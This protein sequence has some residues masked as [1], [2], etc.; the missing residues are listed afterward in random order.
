MASDLDNP[1]AGTDVSDIVAEGKPSLKDIYNSVAGNNPQQ[2]A[3]VIRLSNQTGQPSSFVNQNLDESEK[4]A[5]KP[6]DTL[7]DDIEKQHPVAAR[8]LS[9]PR[10]MAVTHDD[11]PN[12]AAHEGVVKSGI[13]ALN[14]IRLQAEL[15]PLYEERAFTNARMIPGN[16]V[17]ADPVSSAFRSGPYVSAVMGIG[18]SDPAERLKQLDAR[19]K[20]LESQ[21]LG[22]IGWKTKALG[23]LVGLAP[24]VAG[25][26]GYGTAYGAAAGL[27]GPEAVP[28]GLG[29]GELAY[30]FQYGV[31]AVRERL[32]AENQ[33]R[34]TP[35]SDEEINTISV[36]GGALAAGGLRYGMK[37]AA[38]LLPAPVVEKLTALGGK[39]VLE[40]PLIFRRAVRSY[41]TGALKNTA[42]GA[43]GMTEFAAGQIAASD[44]AKASAG[45]K[46]DFGANAQ[47]LG[48]TAKDAALMFGVGAAVGAPFNPKW[49]E[50]KRVEAEQRFYKAMGDTAE[51]SK[52]RERLPE[53]HRR[54]IS[55]LTNNTPVSD[56][57]VPVEAWEAYWQGKTG[58][59]LGASRELG[60]EKQYAEAKATGES[61]KVPLDTW[62]HRLVGTPHFQGLAGDVKFDPEGL[63]PNQITERNA[64][65]AEK[66]AQTQQESE[67]AIKVDAAK[68]EAHDFIKADVIRQLTESGYL[69]GQKGKEKNFEAQ[70]K[71]VAAHYTTEAIRRGVDPKQ[72]YLN[73]APRIL[74]PSSAAKSYPGGPQSPS[75][76]GG[77][78]LG[79]SSEVLS[80]QGPFDPSI[81]GH[82]VFVKAHDEARPIVGDNPTRE[83][84][85]SAYTGAA[86]DVHDIKNIV[87]KKRLAE[88]VKDMGEAGV[89]AAEGKGFTPGEEATL[90]I[91][92]EDAMTRMLKT[93]RLAFIAHN[94]Q[95]ALD[96]FAKQD[97]GEQSDAKLVD[98]YDI[99]P[100]Q[101]GAVQRDAIKTP[102]FK[103]WFGKSKV[104]DAKGKPLVVYHG[105]ANQF[106]EFNSEKGNPE[107]DWGAGFYFTNGKEDVASNYAGFGPDLT[108]KITLR[109]EQIANENDWKYDDPRAQ[110]QAKEELA[111]HGGA[112]M[113]VYLKMEKPFR[114]GGKKETQLTM[115]YEYADPKDPESDIV[116]EK[117]T[118]V[119]FLNNL[120]EVASQYS[121]GGEDV[122]QLISRIAEE[123]GGDSISASRLR[124]LVDAGDQ[125]GIQYYEDENGKLAQHE[126]LRQALERSGFDGVIDE[127][128][129]KKFGSEKRIGKPM[130]GMDEKTIHYIAFKPESIKSAIGN[131]GT[132]D[133]NDPNIL[134]QQQ[135]NVPTFYSKLQRDIEARLPD[136][137]NKGQVEALL[138]DAKEDERKWSGIDEFLK[139]RQKIDK[140]EL[141]EHLRANQLEIKEIEKGENPTEA[142]NA[143]YRRRVEAYHQEMI[144]EAINSAEESGDAPQMTGVRE[145]ED[146]SFS[147]VLG[148][149]V[150]ETGIETNEAATDAANK[151]DEKIRSEWETTIGNNVNYRESED[152]VAEQMKNEGGGPRYSE[153][154]LPGGENY[155][156]LLLTMPRDRKARQDEYNRLVESGV[157]LMEA[158]DRSRE[159]HGDDFRSSH[160]DEPNILAHVRFNDRTDADGK[161]VLFIEEVQSDW[162]QKGRREGYKEPVK[163]WRVEDGKFGESEDQYFVEMPNGK[164]YS[165]GKG[166]V[167]NETE[168]KEYLQRYFG[169]ISKDKERDNISRVPDAPFKKTWHE[170]ALKRMIRYAAENGY[171][172]LAWTT[173]DQQSE[174]YDLSKQVSAIHYVE[175]LD[176]D[177]HVWASKQEPGNRG[178]RHVE[179]GVHPKERLAD[180][181]GKDIADK[182]IAGQGEVETNPT[183]PKEDT[184]TRTLSG[185]D[186]KVGGEGMKGFYDKILPSFANKFG[187]KWGAEVGESRFLQNPAQGGGTPMRGAEYM[188]AHSLPITDPLRN[189]ALKEGFPLFQGERGFFAAEQKVIGLLKNADPSTFMHES[190]HSWLESSF[191]FV[192]G[193]NATQDY[194][195]HWE[196]MRDWLKIAPDQ[197][198]LTREQQEKFAQ[199]FEDYLHEGRAP[200]EELQGIFSQFR[201]WLTEIYK[202]A[203][204]QEMSQPVRGFMDRMLA[205]DEELERATTE[206]GYQHGE[207]AAI[208]DAD[209]VVQNRVRT[210]QERARQAAEASLL[211]EQI[212]EMKDENRDFLT[213]ERE[214]LKPEVEAQVMNQPVYRAQEDLKSQLKR[215]S[216]PVDLSKRYLED[217]LEDHE[218]AAFEYAA[219]MNGF[220]GGQ[221]L[222]EAIQHADMEKDIKDQLD[223]AM[224][225]YADLRNTERI[226]DAALE[227][228]HT[229]KTGELLALEQQILGDLQHKKEIGEEATRRNRAEA[230]VMA[231]AAKRQA[232]ALLE[233]KPLRDAQAFKI[234]VT[235]ERNSAVRV[236]Q[237]LAKGDYEAAA[238]AKQ[239]QLLNHALAAEAFRNRT[240]IAKKMR[241]LDKFAERGQDL[242]GMPY[243]FAAQIDRLLAD[244]GIADPR[245]PE[246]QKTLLKI[247][248][249][250]D[251]AKANPQD[252]ANATGFIKDEDGQWR[253]ENLREFVARIN[254]NYHGLQLPGS[255]MNA[256]EGQLMQNQPHFT[257]GQLRD[258]HEAVKAISGVGKSFE[259]FLSDFLKGDI[260]DAAKIFRFK[261]EKNISKPYGDIPIFGTMEQGKVAA[262]V[263]SIKSV[264]DGM[265]ST[266]VNL[267]TLAEY[268]DRLEPDGPAKTYIYRPLERA[269]NEETKMR[270]EKA[271]EL[272]AIRK[273]YYSDKDL[274]KWGDTIDSWEQRTAN[275]PKTVKLTREN[276][277]VML[278]NRGSDSNLDRVMNGFGIDEQG[279]REIT[280]KLSKKDHEFAQEIWNYVDKFWP[281]ASALE[282]AVKGIE[283]EKVKARP[284]ETIHG[285]LK[286]GYYPLAYDF[287]KSPEAYKNSLERNALYKQ[288]TTT[289]A[290]TA[291]GFLKSRVTTLD[292]PVRLDFSG[293]YNHLDDVIHDITHR[294]AIIDVARFLNQPDAK[295][296]IM[297]AIGQDG[298]RKIQEDLKSVGSKQAEFLTP[299]EQTI[300]WFRFGTTFA[301]LGYRAI[302]FP[303]RLVEDVANSFREVPFKDLIGSV[304]DTLM[305]PRQSREFVR[306]KSVL[307]S[308]RAVNR[309]RDL[310]DMS[311]EWKGR[312]SLVKQ[313]AFLQDTIA[314]QAMSYPVWT[315]VY[316]NNLEKFG[317]ARARDM[318]D[319]AIVK[320]FG[321][322]REMDKV[323]AQRGGELNRIMSMY[324]SWH[325]MMFNRAWLQGKI[326]GLEYKEGNVG[327]ALAT[328]AKMTAMTWVVPAANEIFWAN[329][330]HNAPQGEDEDQKKKRAIAKAL[331]IPFAYFPMARN[332]AAY[333]VPELLGEK[334]RN[335]R[336]SPLEDSIE[337]IIKTVAQGGNIAGTKMGLLDGKDFDQRFAENAA[338]SASVLLG[339]PQTLNTWMFNFVDWLNNEGEANWRDILT[340]RSKR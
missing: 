180:V 102:E 150:I 43:A 302:I 274:A 250:M 292:R 196:P 183:G 26:A 265:I 47:E 169:G 49:A 113:P 152:A 139:G 60:V 4:A 263:D 68:R 310:I 178:D 93:R 31:G 315:A 329:L 198:K 105:T 115:E 293:L 182:I 175:R 212:A 36:L 258:V 23:G 301:T 131:Q 296:A 148:D 10:N 234:Y 107:S 12:V 215:G 165:V 249:D 244:N 190:A 316:K 309:E 41:L 129:N 97:A 232:Q 230:K 282:M 202:K 288:F 261:V 24:L 149:E 146:G 201:R 194:L 121:G 236:S 13:K 185:L 227:A 95:A 339:Y 77:G 184:G 284:V 226:R 273:R 276:A 308:N 108:Q 123:A 8:F 132:F 126:I 94:G 245:D 291:Q 66:I 287:D 135:P 40:D 330:F 98:P 50:S 96:H 188:D 219:E 298:Y 79:G 213:G 278:L 92:L 87:T 205:T 32:M 318:A 138:R 264:P 270:S 159:S 110:K 314:D 204:G 82:P 297:D 290:H 289:A 340:R 16:V 233:S 89:K 214:R 260:R 35:L 197:E 67:E 176:G 173:G 217:K 140:K 156:E 42:Q 210:L 119:D 228:I 30:N 74:G 186:L 259:R 44:V 51:A 25:G 122:E 100:L 241:F 161:K 192:K 9:D 56:V 73:E 283:P 64:T 247:A 285:T 221:Q 84:A 189:A 255:V 229:G 19:I 11:I 157:P 322:G 243:G 80:Q 199:A 147:V 251:T 90:K 18:A 124:D 333:G 69:T 145:E 328:M 281:Q 319:E 239:Q 193:G 332:I 334:G 200:T 1:F 294:K 78:N 307:M 231:D 168:A 170:F 112:T 72:L 162:H 144:Q 91:R 279:I 252:I 181:V 37:A 28:V 246:Q 207:I 128:V 256:A 109:A 216:D 187:K 158:Q 125:P 118:L 154:Q 103:K 220:A 218:L 237:A 320:T 268:L 101:Q 338:R 70:A 71:L 86:K 99:T 62:V 83:A 304:G 142:E 171:D 21:I 130:E 223:K 166:T 324:Y 143:E 76:E 191:Q 85:I 65:I 224:L 137:A 88:D 262:A 163:P 254:E 5:N 305:D 7:L 151:F 257:L 106:T 2:A 286:G 208:P 155:R 331:E 280:D 114:V 57:H 211:K 160:F 39:K 33:K 313:F 174:R 81:T 222:A 242:M 53:G 267:L 153:Y 111:Q 117:G 38:S 195:D 299:N 312:D 275:G 17:G 22:D 272:D 46:Q 3:R 164:K 6:S 238:A 336:I 29:A 248:Q 20:G 253:R 240:E 277:L 269:W 179:I 271:Q 327:A 172:K 55:D 323:G 225:P 303:R 34:A 325:S 15:G 295:T 300:R 141:L 45:E 58:D 335:Y 14:Y 116:G 127:S 306:S 235:A 337:N 52:L 321:S 167:A 61:V 134:H 209:P 120:R 317:D 63:T 311:K 27:A 48:R 54:L 75:S 133:P 177:F 206:T 266:K 104:K 59:P 326:A 203:R 136:K